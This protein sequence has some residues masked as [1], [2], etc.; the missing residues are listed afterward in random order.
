MLI[1]L[2]TL[3]YFFIVILGILA[4]LKINSLI[5]QIRSHKTEIDNLNQKIYS[6]LREIQF[7]SKIISGFVNKVLKKKNAIFT[8]FLSNALI[9]ILPFK[10]MKNMLLLFKLIKKLS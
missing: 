6:E 2:I 3:G 7:K 10:K 9:W 5:P 8:E 1:F 4:I